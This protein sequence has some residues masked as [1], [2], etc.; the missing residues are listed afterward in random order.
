[1]EAAQVSQAMGHLKDLS[2]VPSKNSG[3]AQPDC[4][5]KRVVLDPAKTSKMAI[6][7]AELDPKLEFELITFL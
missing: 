7:S 1:M 3:L 2:E 4:P 5:T 6:I